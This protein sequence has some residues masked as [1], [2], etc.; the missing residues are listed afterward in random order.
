MYNDS[1]IQSIA[2]KIESKEQLSVS[3]LSSESNSFLE[4]LKSSR[5]LYPCLAQMESISRYPWEQ[6]QF[7]NTKILNAEDMR[8]PCSQ[9]GEMISTLISKTSEIVRA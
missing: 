8:I 5:L 2:L 6:F 9:I 4:I 1:Y 3:T 7:E